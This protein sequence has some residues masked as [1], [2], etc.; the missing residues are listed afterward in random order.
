MNVADKVFSKIA[1]VNKMVSREQIEE[2]ATLQRSQMSGLEIG[3][4]MVKRGY[5][6]DKQY[7]A[8][9]KAQQAHL[10]RRGCFPM[11]GRVPPRPPPSRPGNL[12]WRWR[13]LRLRR[14]RGTWETV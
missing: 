5:L 6:T 14:P 9:R 8:V 11:Q 3:K 7:R 1:L 10:A 4:V 13:G 2:C 12:K